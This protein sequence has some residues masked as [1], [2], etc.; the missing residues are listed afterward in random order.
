MDNWQDAPRPDD[1]DVLRRQVAE[2]EGQ[3]AELRRRLLQAQRLSSV[4]ALAASITHEFN[5]ILTTTIN[6]ARM[7]LRHKDEPTRDK[8]FDKILSAGQR[9]SRITTGMLAFAR[10]GGDRREPTD[11]EPLVREVILLAEKDLQ[12][13]R[14]RWQVD[15]VGTPKAD[16]NATQVQQVLLNLIVNAR[17]AMN[18]GGDLRI[19]IRENRDGGTTDI[20]VRDSGPGMSPE[21]LRRIFEPFF[22]TKERDETGRGG[23]G[24]GLALCRDI[25]ESHRGRIRVESTVGVGTAF[26][27]K[28]PL[29]EQMAPVAAAG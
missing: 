29:V 12:M 14:V 27:L 20:S 5:N 4:G 10:G 7:G 18:G 21:Q 17:Q 8:A 6:Y 23:T 3:N 22:S 25:M 28:F 24:L 1:L 2:L 9:A 11:L 15:V 19:T 13:H 16:V 26:T